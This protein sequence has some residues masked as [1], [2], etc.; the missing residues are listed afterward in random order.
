MLRRV[1]PHLQ[2]EKIAAAIYNAVAY[3]HVRRGRT[4]RAKRKRTVGR[5]AECAVLNED[6][7][8][9]AVSRELHAVIRPRPLAAL[10]DNAIVVDGNIDITNRKATALVY[11][12]GI[13]GRP[14]M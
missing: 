5:M 13:S 10:H 11:V 8:G 6:I 14:L 2:V 7:R 12:D 1:C 9:W 3:R 4:L